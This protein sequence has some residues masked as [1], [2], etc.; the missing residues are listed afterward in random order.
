M[1]EYEEA[2]P[3]DRMEILRVRLELHPK[4][5]VFMLATWPPSDLLYTYGELLI[6]LHTRSL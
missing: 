6:L 1:A 2:P 3:V 5:Q 4:Y